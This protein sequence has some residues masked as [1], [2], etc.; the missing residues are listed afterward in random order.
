MKNRFVAT[1]AA[2]A[3]LL[4]ANAA[5]SVE[6]KVAICHQCSY[7]QAVSIAQDEAQ[8]SLPRLQQGETQFVYV[9]DTQTR[10][11]RYFEVTRDVDESDCASGSG[12]GA[13]VLIDPCTDVWYTMV[14]EVAPE[15]DVVDLLQETDAKFDAFRQE[16]QDFDLSELPIGVLPL[17]SATDLVGP[18]TGAP[19]PH[20]PAL[21]RQGLE[22]AL[23]DAFA[24]SWAQRRLTET[25]FVVK[26]LVNQFLDL[27]L[28]PFTTVHFPDG[29][30]VLVRIVTAVVDENGN[31]EGVIVEIELSSIQGPQVPSIPS[32]PNGFITM[33]GNGLTGNSL[34]LE[35]LGDLFVRGG[36]RVERN[37]SGGGCTSTMECFYR[38]NDEGGFDPWCRLNEPDPQLRDC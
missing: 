14:T 20:E 10:Q 21:L 16:I 25:M 1:L 8:Q 18:A 6:T 26:A 33:F 15:P 2:T 22:N 24:S 7:A 3:L 32:G 38:Q 37:R 34:F 12:S 35:S 4:A 19:D 28:P 27:E 30:E 11:V 17:D 5:N 23:F 13:G 31:F 9:L 36:G 29:T